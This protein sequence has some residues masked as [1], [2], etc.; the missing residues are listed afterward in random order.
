MRLSALTAINVYDNIMTAQ[1][2]QRQERFTWPGETCITDQRTENK[3][4]TGQV[5]AMLRR[6]IF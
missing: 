6:S 2:R 4:V 5:K 3:V 1:K